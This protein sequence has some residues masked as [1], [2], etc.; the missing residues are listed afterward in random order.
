MKKL[1]I[2]VV[3]LFMLIL[4]T[5]CDIRQQF[6]INYTYTDSVSFVDAMENITFDE[7]DDHKKYVVYFDISDFNVQIFASN[8]GGRRKLSTKDK[9]IVLDLDLIYQ[10]VDDY[11]IYLN[12][13]DDSSID[14]NHLNASVGRD[15]F[16]RVYS[17]DILL[18]SSNT[19]L[20]IFNHFLETNKDNLKIIEIAK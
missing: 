14:L 8:Y 1:S 16:V 4:I 15:N 5:G 10:Y 17:G 7:E 2:L 3:L 9:P 12:I 13:L 11:Q 19:K 6:P 18:M 20:E